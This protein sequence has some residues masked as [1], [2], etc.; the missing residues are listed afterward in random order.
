MGSIYTAIGWPSDT[1]LHT[2]GGWGKWTPTGTLERQ[3]QKSLPVG[4][5]DV[6]VQTMEG[7]SEGLTIRT[8]AGQGGRTSSAN[9]NHSQFERK[10][11]ASNR[12]RYHRT[13]PAFNRFTTSSSAYG[14][15][16]R[17][18]VCVIALV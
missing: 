1:H 18:N 15:F 6:P 14:H 8:T 5:Q 10:Q 13:G 16:W 7:S 12:A 2:G 11:F 17:D 4:R 9:Y 3:G